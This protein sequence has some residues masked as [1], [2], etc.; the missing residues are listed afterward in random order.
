[1][2]V[3]EVIDSCV[4]ENVS[5][6]EGSKVVVGIKTAEGFDVGRGKLEGFDVGG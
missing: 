1:V 2:G 5:E 3:G 4:G 6:F